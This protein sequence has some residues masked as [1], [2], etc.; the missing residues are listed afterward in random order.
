MSYFDQLAPFIQ[1]W[2]YREQW[3]TLREVQIEAI[4]IIL[5]T[6]NHLLLAT[7]TASGKTEAAFFP[8]LTKLYQNPSATIGI[9]YVSPLK[10]LIIDQHK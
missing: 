3:D 5:E 7:A 4:K 8:A 6:D 1:E 9:L 10:A 2:I